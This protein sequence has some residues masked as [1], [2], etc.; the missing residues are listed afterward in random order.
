MKVPTDF[1]NDLD[2]SHIHKF[3]RNAHYRNSGYDTADLQTKIG[4]IIF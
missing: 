3:Y 2:L 4:T 1:I